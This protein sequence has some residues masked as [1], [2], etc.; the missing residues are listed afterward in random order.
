MTFTHDPD[1]VSQELPASTSS[2]MTVFLLAPVNRL[3]RA[4]PQ[5]EDS[6]ISAACDPSLFRFHQTL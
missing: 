2:L 5:R 6:T 4:V 3:I 1:R